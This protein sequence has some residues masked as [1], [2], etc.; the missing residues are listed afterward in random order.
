ML[1]GKCI[2]AHLDRN[3]WTPVSELPFYQEISIYPAKLPNDIFL[4]LHKQPFIT[5]HFDSSL[6][7]L[8]LLLLTVSQSS[9]THPKRI[10]PNPRPVQQGIRTFPPTSPKVDK[11]FM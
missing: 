4:S 8:L 1:S 2:T 10:F 3:S 9:V 11:L 5:A 6:H 7:I